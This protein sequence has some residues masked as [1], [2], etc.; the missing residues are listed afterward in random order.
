MSGRNQTVG[1]VPTMGALHK[2]HLKLLNEARGD[3]SVLVSSIFVNPIQFNN[4]KDYQKYPQDI[5]NDLSLMEKAQCDIV[6]VPS[7]EEMY[8]AESIVCLNFGSY[9][10]KLEG[11]FRPGHFNGV[12]I[13]LAKLFNIIRPNRAYFG[14][15]DL[16]QAVIVSKLVEDLLFGI[17]I[18]IVSTMREKDGLASSSRNRR[19]NDDQRKDAARFY[20]A[21]KLAQKKLIEKQPIDAVREQVTR[22]INEQSNMKLEYFEVVNSQ[23]LKPIETINSDEQIS[24]CIAGYVGDIRLLDNIYLNEDQ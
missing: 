7:M 16:Q 17:E 1:F 9:E 20:K 8:P 22:L 10:K 12:G 5:D 14:Q 13:V 11:A 15:K 21:L 6:F 23:T 3:N 2:G 18:K 4:P 24:L 19:L